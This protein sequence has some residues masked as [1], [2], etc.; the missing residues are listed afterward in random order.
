MRGR[1]ELST[2]VSVMAYERYSGNANPA[3]NTE[4]ATRHKGYLESSD[5]RVRNPKVNGLPWSKSYAVARSEP[6]SVKK[7]TRRR[8]RNAGQQG[9]RGGP[10]R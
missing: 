10:T 2:D 9:T 3:G 7:G 4:L 1:T 8:G 6:K 5:P